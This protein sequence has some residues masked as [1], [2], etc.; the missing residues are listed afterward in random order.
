MSKTAR[1]KGL[2]APSA[3]GARN[4][5]CHKL[6]RATAIEMAGELYDQCMRNNDIYAHWKL[7]CPELTPIILEIQ[8]IELLWPKMIEPARATLAR[9]LGMAHIDEKQKETIYLALIHDAQLRRGRA[10]G[11]QHMPVM[12]LQ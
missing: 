5:H 8:F 10:D 11:T 2:A 7:A 12:T 3:A 6:I 4:V 9:M 1:P